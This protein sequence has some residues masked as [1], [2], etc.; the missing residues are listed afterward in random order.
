MHRAS[1]I[2]SIALVCLLLSKGSAINVLDIAGN[3]PLH[4]AFEECHP[5]VVIELLKQ[6]ADPSQ[7]NNDDKTPIEVC[8]DIDVKKKV[9]MA[10]KH[11]G[12]KLLV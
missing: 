3:T 8:G 2:G 4:H 6:G 1:A 12:I 9:L 10:C 11:Q 7:K 5:D